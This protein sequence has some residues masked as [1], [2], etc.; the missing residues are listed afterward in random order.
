M[1]DPSKSRPLSRLVLVAYL[2]D[3]LRHFE[4]SK[5]QRCRCR[6]VNVS[7]QTDSSG[8]NWQANFVGNKCETDCSA[9]V[10]GIISE[11]RCDGDLFS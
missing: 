4:Q 3:E 10:Q 5:S 1:N 9:L 7:A 2:N 6:I 11:L 8:L